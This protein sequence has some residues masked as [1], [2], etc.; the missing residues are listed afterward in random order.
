MENRIEVSQESE[1]VI[2]T[3]QGE[4]DMSISRVLE[5]TLK[6]LVL[7]DCRVIAISRMRS[8]SIAR[9]FPR[10]WRAIALPLRA[11]GG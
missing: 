10:C 5:G 4:H 7:A 8:S 1:T 2:V 11:G 9:S 6:G 3:L